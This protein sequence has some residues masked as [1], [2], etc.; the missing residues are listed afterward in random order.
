[1]KIYA[2]TKGC[3]SDYHICALT[4][5]K[6]K[7]KKLQEIYSDKYNEADIEEYEDGEGEELRL[8]W[9]CDKNGLNPEVRDYYGE[10]EKI[11]IDRFGEICGVYIYA[12][13]AGHAEKKAHDMLAQYQAERIGL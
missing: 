7:A 3:Y 13:D 10:E 8:L 11:L 9:F 5:S 1:M 2:I 6:S 12:K 4:T